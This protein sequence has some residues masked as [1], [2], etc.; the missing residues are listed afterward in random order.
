MLLIYVNNMNN[1]SVKFIVRINFVCFCSTKTQ[2]DETQGSRCK[3]QRK[4]W[5]SRWQFLWVWVFETDLKV[6]KSHLLSR[7]SQLKKHKNMKTLTALPSIL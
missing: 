5:L 7:A 2:T 4:V 3:T 1:S 6:S